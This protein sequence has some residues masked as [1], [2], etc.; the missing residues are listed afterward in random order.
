[1]VDEVEEVGAAPAHGRAAVAEGG[2][3][4]PDQRLGV[5]LLLEV[6]RRGLD[7]KVE[8]VGE[9]LA[10]DELRVEVGVAA[11]PGGADGGAGG[12][13]EARAKLRPAEPLSKPEP[14]RRRMKA[15]EYDAL[16]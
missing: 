3:E 5:D 11:L 6:D 9:V 15:P 8:P 14:E 10:P 2:A 16:I 12:V 13:R 1:M 7:D 4:I